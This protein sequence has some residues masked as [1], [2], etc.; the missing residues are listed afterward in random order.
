MSLSST[1]TVVSMESVSMCWILEETSSKETTESVIEE[2]KEQEG[3][4]EAKSVAGDSHDK[5]DTALDGVPAKMIQKEEEQEEKTDR[6][7]HTLVDMNF[8]IKKGTSINC[9]CQMLTA[10]LSA[11]SP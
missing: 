3:T 8:R 11:S 7:G 2:T 10:L 5:N 1:G 6:S 9:H 4:L